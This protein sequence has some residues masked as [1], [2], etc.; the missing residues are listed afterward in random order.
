[1]DIRNEAEMAIGDTQAVL[2]D[3]TAWMGN[4]I[5]TDQRKDK[6]IQVGHQNTA[7][8][9]LPTSTTNSMMRA[10]IGLSLLLN[11]GTAWTALASMAPPSYC[12]CITS[13]AVACDLS[14]DLP[15]RLVLPSSSIPRDFV[16]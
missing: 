16:N 4:F 1:M 12:P 3:A 6:I 2:Q 13:K 15:C 5:A 9:L 10:Y 14:V 11:L 7:H 8:Q